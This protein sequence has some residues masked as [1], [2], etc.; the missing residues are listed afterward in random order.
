MDDKKTEGASRKGVA[1]LVTRIVVTLVLIIA[2]V[3][4]FIST[5]RANREK[6]E[7]LRCTEN[8]RTLVQAAMQY[9]NDQ[10]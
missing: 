10:R 4:I 9:S 5:M 8:L 3:A 7:K 6:A 2:G 1:K